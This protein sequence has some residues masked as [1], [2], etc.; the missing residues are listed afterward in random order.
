MSSFSLKCR[1]LRRQVCEIRSKSAIPS[2]PSLCLRNLN[3]KAGYYRLTCRAGSSG[4]N[5][6]VWWRRNIL[7]WTPLN[8]VSQLNHCS[9][10]IIAVVLKKILK[11]IQLSGM[12]IYKLIYFRKTIKNSLV[13]GIS[14]AGDVIIAWHLGGNGKHPALV[15]RSSALLS[16]LGFF[17]LTCC[18]SSGECP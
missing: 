8:V 11:Y 6:P 18:C 16:F 1:F 12:N 15:Y 14:H 5:Y 9:T 10:E 17:S 13:P 2:E 4:D 3:E 7:G